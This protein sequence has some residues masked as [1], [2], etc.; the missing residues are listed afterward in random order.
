MIIG[1]YIGKLKD[2]EKAKAENLEKTM[3]AVAAMSKDKL[4]VA[5][6]IKIK[7]D[8]ELQRDQILQ[9]KEKTA[10]ALEQVYSVNIIHPKYRGLLPVAM[11]CEYLETGR[12]TQLEGAEGAYNLYEQ[13]VRLDKICAK[14]DVMIEQLDSI[15]ENQYHLY[16]VL[17]QTNHTL[18][19]VLAENKLMMHSLDAIQEN[20]ELIAYNTYANKV[21]MGVATDIMIFREL[22]P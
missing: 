18:S 22:R 14:L 10:Q 2:A 8:I 12:C 1:A 21:M 13:E 17:S 9:Q 20:T 3:D 5:R 15:R 7:R 16:Q 19:K 11:F 4:R 6:E